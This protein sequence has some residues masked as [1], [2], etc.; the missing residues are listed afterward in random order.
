[1]LKLKQVHPRRCV[2][3]SYWKGPAKEY[4]WARIKPHYGITRW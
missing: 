1:M 3:F 2:D 4:F